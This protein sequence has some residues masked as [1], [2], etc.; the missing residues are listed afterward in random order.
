MHA[1]FHNEHIPYAVIGTGIETHNDAVGE[2][3]REQHRVSDPFIIYAGRISP[4]KNCHELFTFFLRYKEESNTNLKLILLGRAEM[5]IPDHEDIHCLG[6]VS[7]QEKFDGFRA[8]DVMVVPSRYESL[9]IVSLESM[10]VGTPLLVNGASD[11]LREHCIRSN[12][13]LYYR[14]YEEFST[15]LTLLL[16]HSSLRQSL[17][18]QGMAYVAQN[19]PWDRMESRYLEAIEYVVDGGKPDEAEHQR[20]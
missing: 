4:S 8:A 16:Q 2:R 11:V 5:P 9:S 7:E 18:R 1:R 3:F 13:G 14:S 6:F 19:Y 10:A 17:G 15:S 12:G 20:R